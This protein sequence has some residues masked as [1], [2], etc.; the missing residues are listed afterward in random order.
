MSRLFIRIV[1]MDWV[2]WKYMVNVCVRGHFARGECECKHG[3]KRKKDFACNYGFRIS[4]GS[5]WVCASSYLGS[6]GFLH[7]VPLLLFQFRL[8]SYLLEPMISKLSWCKRSPVSFSLFLSLF[9]SII[10]A[11]LSFLIEWCNLIHSTALECAQLQT[12]EFTTKSAINNNN[13]KRMS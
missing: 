9:L 11:L 4:L 2:R 7:R 5:V 10:K 13:N 3:R 1:P 6:S 8:W 12:Y